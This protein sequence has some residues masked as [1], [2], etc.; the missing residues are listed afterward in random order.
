MFPNEKK[1]NFYVKWGSNLKIPRIAF[2]AVGFICIFTGIILLTMS[3]NEGNLEIPYKL[4]GYN[5]Y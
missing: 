2:S 3:F 1:R 4:C 5:S